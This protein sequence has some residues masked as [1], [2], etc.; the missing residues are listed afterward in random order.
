MPDGGVLTMAVAGYTKTLAIVSHL[1]EYPDPAWWDELPAYKAAVKE[2]ESQQARGLLSEFI[3]YVEGEEKKAYEEQYVRSFDFSM[4]TNLY[5]TTQ[6]RTDYGKQS[7]EMHRYKV[8]FLE[9]G[10]D[11]NR[12]LPDYLPA[13]L[14]LA[15]SLQA[16]HAKDVLASIKPRVELL[17]S[18][19]IEAKLAQSFLMDLVL[20]ETAGLEVAS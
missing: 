13:L 20:M 5:L 12:Q 11:V 4:N 1:L 7:E 17:R 19:F 15:A 8:L 14:E 10:Y 18:R 2:I 3:D 9:N 6:E 16:D